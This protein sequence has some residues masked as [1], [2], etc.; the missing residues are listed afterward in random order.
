MSKRSRLLLWATVVSL[1]GWGATRLD[2]AEHP[3]TTHAKEHAGKEHAGTATQTQ[4]A[5]TQTSAT[6]VQATVTQ[7]T[8]AEPAVMQEV[9]GKT[10]EPTNQEIRMAMKTYALEVTN[11][12]GGFFPIHDEKTGTDRKLTFQRVH[13]RVGKLSTRDGYFSCADFNDQTSGEALD[14]DFWVTMQN[15]ILQVTGSEI[16]KVNGQARF[17]YNEKDEKIFLN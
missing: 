14:V 16:H 9:V 11:Q 7:A 4:A 10:L 2:A 6:P 1:V 3:G 17:T 8:S 5:S 15:G 12:N 13:E